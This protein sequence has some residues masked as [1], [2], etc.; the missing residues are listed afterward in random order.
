[1][2]TQL[3]NDAGK[4]KSKMYRAKKDCAEHKKGTSVVSE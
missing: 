2:F 1:M 3:F 4:N